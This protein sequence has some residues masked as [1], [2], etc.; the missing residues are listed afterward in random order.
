M[1]HRVERKLH[2]AEALIGHLIRQRSG[3]LLVA[4]KLMD[5]TDPDLSQ[6]AH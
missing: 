4:L 2:Q 3:E 1:S 5:L 6:V